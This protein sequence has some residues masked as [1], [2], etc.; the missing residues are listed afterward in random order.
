MQEIINFQ[1]VLLSIIFPLSPLLIVYAFYY[2]IRIY[3][4]DSFFEKLL[5]RIA[6]GYLVFNVFYIFIPAIINLINPL[7]NQYL[8]STIIIDLDSTGSLTSGYWETTLNSFIRYWFQMCANSFLNY[9]FYPIALLPVIFILGAILSFFL[10]LYQLKKLDPNNNL[11]TSLSNFQFSVEDNPISSM[12]EKLKNP[13]WESPKDLV[14]ILLAVLPISLYLLMTL[15]KVTGNQE[16]PNILQ[17]TSLGWFLEIFFVYLAAGMFSVHL[18]YSGRFSFKGDYLGLKLRKAMIQSLSTVGTLMSGIAIILFVIDYSKQLFVVVYFVSYFIMVTIFFALFLD[19]FEPISIYLLTKMVENFKRF[20]LITLKLEP[21]AIKTPSASSPQHAEIFVPSVNMNELAS[22]QE[23]FI[24]EEVAKSSLE[25]QTEV[26]DTKP[27]EIIIEPRTLKNLFMISISKLLLKISLTTLLLVIFMKILG[28]AIDSYDLKYILNQ[29]ATASQTI[30]FVVLFFYLSIP[31]LLSVYLFSKKHLNVAIIALIVHS[32]VVMLDWSIREILVN[33]NGS[34]KFET[35]SYQSIYFNFQAFLVIIL[36]ASSLLIMRRYNWNLFSNVSLLFTTGVIMVITWIFI[37]T[38]DLNIIIPFTQQQLLKSI[39]INEI[40]ILQSP[41]PTFNSLVVGLLQI[42]ETWVTF[43]FRNVSV[44]S[45][46]ATLVIPFLSTVPVNF[47]PFLSYLSLPFRFLQPLSTF[48]LYAVVFFFIKPEFLTVVYK[49]DEKVE[50]IVYS[51]RLTNLKL[52]EVSKRPNDYS[53]SRNFGLN[54]ENEIKGGFTVT[55]IE[56]SIYQFGIGA[57]IV[58]FITDAPITFADLMEDSLLSLEEI[59]NFFDEISKTALSKAKPFIFFTKEYGFSYEEANLDS[60]HVMMVD[61]RSV[62]TH[63]FTDESTVEPALVAGLFSAIT[64]FAKETVKSEQLL[65]T[66]DH[67]DVVLM[68]EYGQYVFSAIFA[69][70]NSVELRNKL[71]EFVGIFEEKHAEELS[72]WLGDTSPFS[73]D[74]M[75]VNEIF[76]VE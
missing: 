32:L 68:I 71:T 3:K 72:G 40:N 67:G 15:L 51:E 36:L 14:K 46:N 13:N 11:A 2:L 31:L 56:E 69:D 66:I 60:L 42:G 34:E 21:E 70:K 63:N 41:V 43:V 47:V 9:I 58:Q 30:V 20:S 52:G 33:W 37:F 76:K 5:S 19:I 27:K 24:P 59:I 54:D 26:V 23:E 75:I 8:F 7:E 12:F 65:R 74:W 44:N 28:L 45:L 39:P 18:L 57:H 1:N 64:S 49:D 35:S 61:G 10:I 48:F 53:I 55:Q 6:L 17:G 22:P 16:N 25:V 29:S 38:E 50:K 73:D 4:K 62:F